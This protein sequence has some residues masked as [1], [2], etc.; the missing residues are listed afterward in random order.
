MTHSI[1]HN[2]IRYNPVQSN[3]IRQCFTKRASVST[4]LNITS[5]AEAKHDISLLNSIKSGGFILFQKTGT[6]HMVWTNS[7]D[8]FPVYKHKRI[9]IRSQNGAH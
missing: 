7:D 3:A 2:T 4:R 9:C 5:H 1:Q 8:N 6:T